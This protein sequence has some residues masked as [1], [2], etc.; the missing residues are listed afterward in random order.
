MASSETDDHQAIEKLEV[1]GRHDEQ[2][3]SGD[4]WRMITE[5]GFPTL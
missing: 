3:D 5:E 2:I 1:D 4:V